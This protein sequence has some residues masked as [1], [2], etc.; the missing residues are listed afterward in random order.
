M[1]LQ[2]IIDLGDEL[3]VV[4]SNKI[5]LSYFLYILMDR[6]SANEV[7]YSHQ[8][9][10][11]NVKYWCS[12]GR[13]IRR[14]KTER[15]NGMLLLWERPGVGIHVPGRTRPVNLFVDPHCIPDQQEVRRKTQCL[16]RQLVLPPT[17]LEHLIYCIVQSS[18]PSSLRG[19]IFNCP[20]ISY[21]IYHVKCILDVDPW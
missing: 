10:L 6:Q 11:R 18:E 8:T 15:D 5:W 1:S 19:S 20:D 9:E 16:A 14:P 3:N 2:R 4:I 21:T 13:L 12:P 17:L 7:W